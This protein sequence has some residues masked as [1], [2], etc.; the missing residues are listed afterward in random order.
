VAAA[1]RVR[2][3]RKIGNRAAIPGIIGTAVYAHLQEG[4]VPKGFVCRVWRPLFKAPNPALCCNIFRT[5]FQ[6]KKV[7]NHDKNPVPRHLLRTKNLAAKQAQ[8]IEKQQ[9]KPMQISRTRFI[10]IRKN[11]LNCRYAN[12]LLPGYLY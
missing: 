10:I 3:Q 2:K 6:A 4:L 7:L 9:F 12:K 1:Y 11:I 8:N 5:F